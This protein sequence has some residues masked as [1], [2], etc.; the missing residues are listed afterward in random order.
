MV[1]FLFFFSFFFFQIFFFHFFCDNRYCFTY[2]KYVNLCGV[3]FD[4]RCSDLFAVRWYFDVLFDVRWLT[5]GLGFRLVIRLIYVLCRWLFC[6]MLFMAW[7]CLIF[8]FRVFVLRESWF[9]ESVGLVFGMILIVMRKLDLD[10]FV[11]RIWRV[12]VHTC[13]YI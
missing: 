6:M 4:F 13:I 3:F 7:I 10:G 5:L 12:C 11:Y 8:L 9:V 1:R 2:F